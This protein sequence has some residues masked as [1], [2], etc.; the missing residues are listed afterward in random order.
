MHSHN[1]RR[2]SSFLPTK[3]QIHLVEMLGS[4]RARPVAVWLKFSSRCPTPAAGPAFVSWRTWIALVLRTCVERV[5]ATQ[6]SEA[7]VDN[8]TWRVLVPRPWNGCVHDRPAES[9]C[10]RHGRQAHKQLSRSVPRS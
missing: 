2:A 4:P 8:K 5:A 10:A 9:G 6:R 3:G 1:Q 7:R